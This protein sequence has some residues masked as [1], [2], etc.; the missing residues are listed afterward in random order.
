ML[1]EQHP[2]ILEAVDLVAF[3]S[4][5]QDIQPRPFKRESDNRVCFEFTQDVRP[6][7]DAF[8][9]NAPTPISD[10]CKNLKFV[11]SMIYNLRGGGV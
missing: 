11:K 9:R 7:I 1:K 4:L 3:I 2:T 10:F 6:S 5:N 8:Y